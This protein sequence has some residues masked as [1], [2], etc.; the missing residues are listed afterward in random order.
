VTREAGF[1]PGA[2]AAE[3]EIP[4]AVPYLGAS[5][6]AYVKEALDTIWV[7]SLGPFVDRFEREVAAVLDSPHAVAISSVKRFAWILCGSGSTA[8]SS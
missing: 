2:P 6:W 4:L 3:G 8:A 5:E 7:S 1:A